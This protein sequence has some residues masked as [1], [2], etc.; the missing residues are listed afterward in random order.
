M[1]L[2]DYINSLT[3]EQRAEYALRCGTTDNYLRVHVVR[4]TKECRKR[5]REALASESQGKVTL[6]E[7]LQ[8]FGIIPEKAA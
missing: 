1:K 3:D 5:L 6:E 8:H 2:S 4:A 7:V